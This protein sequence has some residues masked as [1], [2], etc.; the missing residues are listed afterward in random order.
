MTD[1]QIVDLFW[2]RSENAIR[3][4]ELKYGRLCRS[5]AGNIVKN[6]SDAEECVNDAYLRAWNAIPPHRPRSYQTFLCMLVKRVSLDR[7]RH[8]DAKKR[9]VPAS[10]LEELEELIGSSA[11]APEAALDKEELRQTV[12]EFLS[13]QND[14]AR[15]IFLRRYWFCEPIPQIAAD[16]GEKEER[17]ASQ[18][19][20]TRKK[21]RA[22]LAK[23]G[24][25]P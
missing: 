20:R 2:A 5:L 1:E 6:P 16:L 7:V 18:L 13:K 14:R 25:L 9:G 12:G 19:F 17:I 8:N 22:Y 11:E 21:L 3:E 4:T 24:F 15:K 10:F 23:E